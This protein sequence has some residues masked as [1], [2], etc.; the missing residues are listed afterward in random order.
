MLK[1]LLAFVFLGLLAVLQGCS[2][3][4]VRPPPAELQSITPEIELER[5]WRLN[6]GVGSD[7]QIL[8]LRPVFLDGVLYVVD[9][10]GLITAVE[11]LEGD[12]L[13]EWESDRYITAGLAGAD[14]LLFM[15][16]EDGKLL[17]FDILTQ[18]IVWEVQ[19]SSESVVKPVLAKDVVVVQT[20]DGR[21]TAFGRKDG[22]KRWEYVSAAEPALTLRG[23]AVPVE[24][25]NTI[26]AGL[27]NGTVVSLSALT[28][29]LL[30]E[31]RVALPKG[32]TELERLIDIDSAL[33]M[34][35]GRLFAV[36]FQGR[37]VELDPF[38][39]A[40]LWAVDTSSYAD[41]GLGYNAVYLS[42]PDGDVRAFKRDGGARVWVNSELSYRYLGA[43]LAWDAYILLPDFEGYMHVLTQAEG[44]IVGR[45]RPGS[46]EGIRVPAFVVDD[47]IYIYTNDGTLSAWRREQE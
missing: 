28:G 30:W 43:V 46:D 22:Q 42:T 5:L 21:L 44:R 25:E 23:N 10:E 12:R 2:D 1:F 6:A 11:P 14:N 18:A 27:S 39:G 32:R 7:G 15:A 29:E 9:A 41:L 37:L 35:D 36:A 26:I 17:A 47:I 34:A 31:Q 33:L 38:N 24:F 3:D 19:L 40:V 16:E 20:I 8:D 13:W 4:D 45:F